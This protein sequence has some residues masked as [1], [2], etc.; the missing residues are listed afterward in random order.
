MNNFDGCELA[1]MLVGA[2][3]LGALFMLIME[4]WKDTK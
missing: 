2:F 4:H 3:A 1:G